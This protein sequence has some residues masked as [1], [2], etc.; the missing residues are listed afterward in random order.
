MS[1][2]GP[3]PRDNQLSVINRS[4]TS[5]TISQ[6]IVRAR[7]TRKIPVTRHA[8][9]VQCSACAWLQQIS[10][11]RSPRTTQSL[12][13]VLGYSTYVCNWAIARMYV[14]ANLRFTIISSQYIL[15]HDA[16][17]KTQQEVVLFLKFLG[18][19]LPALHRWSLLRWACSCPP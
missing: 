16:G 4:C 17:R 7:K 3:K 8:L 12:G 9:Q 19:L 5:S 1:V 10:S 14:T 6:A 11:S 18:F 13:P 15:T 2:E